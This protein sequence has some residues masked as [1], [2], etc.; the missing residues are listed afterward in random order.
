[1]GKT[2]SEKTS[3]AIL[4]HF[5]KNPI[6]KKDPT[7]PL[8]I[9]MG[10]TG[11]GKTSLYNKVCGTSYV[12]RSGK[13]SVTRSLFRHDVIFCKNSF[14]LMDFPGTDSQEETIKHAILLREG[15]TATKI[16]TIFLILE[17]DS[18]FERLFKN[19]SEVIQPVLNHMDHIV[20]MISHYD[21]SQD[22]NDFKNICD[23]FDVLLFFTQR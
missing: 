7:K 15:L 9:L 19:Y 23:E 1:M 17:F 13:G 22:P 12:S 2:G 5:N 10:K 4:H 20:V 3:Y 18:R 14:G 8:G 11:S 16:N 21:K 6:L